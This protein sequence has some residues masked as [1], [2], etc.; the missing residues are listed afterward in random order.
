MLSGSRKQ[1]AARRR[2]SQ[3]REEGAGGAEHQPG[4]T[5]VA[6]GATAAA[7]SRLRSPKQQR[8]SLRFSA[9]WP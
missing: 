9:G 6:T 2:R 1:E 4:R 3:C 8:V 7:G 5:L